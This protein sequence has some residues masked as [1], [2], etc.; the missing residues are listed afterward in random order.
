MWWEMELRII[1]LENKSTIESIMQHIDST[2]DQVLH[3]WRNEALKMKKEYENIMADNKRMKKALI[4]I[5]SLWPEPPFCA[6]IMQVSGINDGRSRAIIAD[7][8][9]TIAREGLINA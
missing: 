4:S 1:M 9:I 3:I 2:E 7:A 8:A 6:D 5:S